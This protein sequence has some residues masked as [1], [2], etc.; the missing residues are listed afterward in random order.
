MGKA[1]RTSI[2]CVEWLTFGAHLVETHNTHFLAVALNRYDD[3]DK[4]QQ[5]TPTDMRIIYIHYKTSSSPL[6][7]V[8][9]S[10]KEIYGRKYSQTHVQST[11]STRNSSLKCRR[12]FTKTHIFAG[13]SILRILI[14]SYML[15]NV[16]LIHRNNWLR[17]SCW[18]TPNE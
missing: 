4:Y 11:H 5:I 13:A 8:W 18:D 6:W 10:E 7:H 15:Y 17:E 3:F 1:T 9:L 2:S 12:K 14:Q 16:Y